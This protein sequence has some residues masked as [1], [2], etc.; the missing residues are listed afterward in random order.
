MN[1]KTL[2]Q[3]I[4]LIDR[5]VKQQLVAILSHDKFHTLLENWS[6]LHYLI[7]NAKHPTTR[8]KILDVR[9]AEISRSINEDYT[10]E[11]VFSIKILDELELPGNDPLSIIIGSYHLDLSNKQII[12]TLSSIASICSY[13]FVPFISTTTSAVFDIK[14]LSH[15]TKIDLDGIHKNNK[16]KNFANLSKDINS[17]FIAIVAPRIYFPSLISCSK[18]M[19]Y[20]PILGEEI[21]NYKNILGNGAFA[22][23]AVVMNSFINTRWFLDIVGFPP[24][25][26]LPKD[27]GGEFGIVPGVKAER[28]CKEYFDSS[29]FLYKYST[30]CFISERREKS[31]SD[32][33]FIPV[34]HIK[35]GYSPI[36]HSNKCVRKL[37]SKF[38]KQDSE[39]ASNTL[40][41]ILSVC[42]FAHYIKIIGRQKIGLF[43][44][45]SELQHFLNNWLLQY[46]SSDPETPLSL[47]H[48]YPL[49]QAKVEVFE[50]HFLQNNFKCKIYLKPHLISSQVIANITLTTR[51]RSITNISSK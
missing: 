34:C 29:N 7:R 42:R 30:E 48:K 32:L 3:L 19:I 9:W 40:Q 44:D 22:F 20:C 26:I 16:F 17:S 14:E 38:I 21:N 23:V 25:K 45:V 47:K 6:C 46:V 43:S 50:D 10:L 27:Y 51:I 41:N 5:L 8:V 24:E 35:D 33:G 11:N 18:E 39:D 13:C 1:K 4:V 12:D 36:F 15:L 28:F 49:L 2:R 37:Q 31:L